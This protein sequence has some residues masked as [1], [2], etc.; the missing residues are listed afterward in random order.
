MLEDCL[1]SRKESYVKQ[2]S[3]VLPNSGCGTKKKKVA[4][5][6]SME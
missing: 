4:V 2:E 1:K 3:K 6:S 5:G